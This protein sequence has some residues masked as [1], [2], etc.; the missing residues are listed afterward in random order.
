MERLQSALDLF[1]KYSGRYPRIE[2]E[3]IGFSPDLTDAGRFYIRPVRKGKPLGHQSMVLS[4]PYID[5][6]RDG[7]PEITFR[8]ASGS[9]PLT[10]LNR[11]C[12]EILQ[13]GML[14]GRRFY[15]RLSRDPKLLPRYYIIQLPEKQDFPVEFATWPAIPGGMVLNP[16]GEARRG[17][18]HWS[19]LVPEGTPEH[20]AIATA[21]ELG[22][23]ARLQRKPPGAIEKL[24]EELR[25]KLAFVPA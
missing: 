17:Y 14:K 7:A 12:W 5:V 22:E 10:H 16:E 9:A 11:Q 18:L 2:M 24:Q 6:M 19:A 23:T 15:V 13:N 21:L 1:F 20:D 3:P 4:Y 8:P 25:R